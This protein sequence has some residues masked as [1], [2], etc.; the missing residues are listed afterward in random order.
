MIIREF[1]FLVIKHIFVFLKKKLYQLYKGAQHSYHEYRIGTSYGE[2]DIC[3]IQVIIAF[4]IITHIH[5]KNWSQA[6]VAK[7]RRKN[8][9][10]QVI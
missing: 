3:D 9:Y 5:L 4:V 2:V 1:V 8:K 7:A 10:K 6:S